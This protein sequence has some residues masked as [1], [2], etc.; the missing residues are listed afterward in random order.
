MIKKLRLTFESFRFAFQA[1]RSNVTR[2]VLSLLGVSIGIFAIIAV[3]TFVDSME[4]NIKGSLNF[5]GNNVLYVQKWAWG[6]EDDYPWWKYFQRP[7]TIYK[8]F[9]YLQKRL[10]NAQAVCGIDARGG[11][12]VKKGSNSFD[13]LVFGITYQYNIISE[14]PVVD[15]RYFTP[16]EMD[17]GRPVAVLGQMVA[18]T[19]FPNGQAIG[20]DFKIKGI[21]FRV[22]GVQEKKGK[23][24]IDLGGDPDTKVII[25]Y[26][27]FA[28][29]FNSGLA[30]IDIAAKAFESDKNAEKLSSEITGLM[31]SKRSLRP[32][33]ED[34]FS[35]NKPEA[36]AS[37][38]DGIFAVLTLAGIV[39]GGFSILVG[40]FGIANIMFVSVKERTNIIGIQKS[41]GAKTS[42]ILWQFLFES[43]CL[44][45]IGGFIGLGLVYL[46]TFIPIGSFDVILSYKN[47]VTGLVIA[48]ALG[49]IFGIIPALMAAKLNPVEAI[50]SK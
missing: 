50:R 23:S 15:G 26:L 18:Q 39:I 40:G 38:L 13:A 43:I 2:T 34:N 22:I 9:T 14:V 17:A 41:L 7:P 30:E 27:A 37:A 28:K 20:Q 8:E 33:Q 12:S 1:L 6:T 4:K 32:S 10:E 19:L 47:I 3:F 29:M 35:I 44:C 36:I 16:Q 46:I 11:I 21:N 49:L 45:L 42:F 25:P 48:T 24:L 5:F 31:R